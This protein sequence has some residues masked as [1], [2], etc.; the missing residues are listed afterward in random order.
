[1]FTYHYNIANKVVDT[2]LLLE[3]IRFSSITI[4]VD[5]INTV[6]TDM[7]INFKAQLS[8]S[9]M[10]QLAAIVNAHDGS[11]ALIS[12][13]DKTVLNWSDFKLSTRS[14][15]NYIDLGIRYYLWENIDGQ[16]ICCDLLKTDTV[17]V[18]DFE[19]NYK[20][21]YNKSRDVYNE[22]GVK[23]VSTSLDDTRGLYPKKNMFGGWMTIVPGE[24]TIVDIP[25][26]N[27]RRLFGGEFWIDTDD[28][29]AGNVDYRDYVE[30]SVV[31][32]DD[33][34]GLFSIYALSKDNGDILELCKFVSNHYIK[35]GT[36]SNGYY[37]DISKGIKGTNQVYSGLYMRTTVFSHGT[38][39][40]KFLG[41]F[42]YYETP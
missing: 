40:Y 17:S 1:M 24:I 6:A 11:K 26:S 29:V 19:T 36:P 2:N 28:A 25:V 31:D 27:E 41:N 30:F 15:P 33:I 42:F 5:S 23:V 7:G 14:F 18:S 8:P 38:L 16:T 12:G 9:E 37:S 32:K 22:F 4:A 20:S 39:S 34:L 3:Q 10:D 21:G 35:K 13:E